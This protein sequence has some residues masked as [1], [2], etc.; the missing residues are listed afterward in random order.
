M[1][2][3]PVTDTW[4]HGD[5]YERYVGRWSRR[6][7]PAF[8]DW[9]DLPGGLRWV[10]VGCGTGALSSAILD[11]AS[12]ASVV[13][14][15]PS[16][17]FL[18]TARERL[19]DRMTFH[20][21]GAEQLP[22]ADGSA[23]VVVSGLVLNFV[24][25]QLRALREAARVA[26]GGAVAAY[27]WDYAEGMEFMRVFWDAAAS[28]DHAAAEL[29]EAARFPIATAEGLANAFEAAGLAEVHVAAVDIPTVFTD[30]DDLWTPF[31]GGQGSAPSYVATLDEPMRNA[32]RDAMRERVAPAGDG[33]I[34]MLAR[35]WA[36]RGAVRGNP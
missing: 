23:D 7:A 1:S 20:G 36:A 24:P 35:A 21:A 25:D 29:D 4:A 9:L 15:E 12:P 22:L 30:F 5:A 10:D 33:S 19:G 8:L 32:V 13:G 18:A 34:T 16:P 2:S 31:L 27:V 26:G 28:V 3:E 11:L 14:V 17:G 6:V